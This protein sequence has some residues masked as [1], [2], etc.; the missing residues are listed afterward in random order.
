VTTPTRNVL[1]VDDDEGLR[2]L[3]R[4]ALERRGYSVTVAATGE[5]GL[6]LAK[7]Q[8]F[9]VI[10]LDHYMPGLGGFETLLELHRRPD[11]PPIVYVTGSDESRVAVSALKAGAADYV[12]KAIGEEFFDLLA[13]AFEQALE[14]VELRRRHARAEAELLTTNAR[15]EALLREVNH[16]V[17]NSLQMVSAFVHMQASAL[18]GAAR[19]ALRDT[20]RRIEAIGQVHRRLYSSTDVESVDMQDYLAAL[21]DELEDTLSSPTSPRR[22]SLDAAPVRLKTDKAVSVGVIVNELVTNACKYAYARAEAGDVR[23]RLA[24]DGAG[25]TLTVEDDGCGMVEGHAA[26][27]TGLGGRLITAMA[28]SLQ[29]ELVYDPNHAGVRAVLRL[30]SGAIA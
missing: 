30:P 14:Q 21:I 13:N 19:S 5:E 25:L 2:R 4:K 15:L 1:Y 18:D 12:V 3:V 27:G 16:R 26:Q 9:D 24:D 7:T 28:R 11:P 10:A 20:E 23:I 22:L 6:V 29:T 17:A 8:A